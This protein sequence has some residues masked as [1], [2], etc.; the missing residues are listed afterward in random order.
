MAGS[1]ARGVGVGVTSIRV[2]V[3][4]GSVAADVVDDSN[5]DG[6][7]AT[8]VAAGRSVELCVAPLVLSCSR[9]PSDSSSSSTWTEGSTL[10]DVGSVSRRSSPL[11]LESTPD[12]NTLS[13]SSTG[14]V[15]STVGE[16]EEEEEDKEVCRVESGRDAVSSG[17]ADVT[18]ADI[19][20]VAPSV[21]PLAEELAGRVETAVGVPD[22]LV[23]VTVAGEI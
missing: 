19:S 22:T 7:D 6:V 17:S 11:P 4:A 10:G 15:G 5:G 3:E 2:L 18:D 21:L 20:G 14:G 16:E 23:E 1:V 9:P 12:P 8:C 13:S